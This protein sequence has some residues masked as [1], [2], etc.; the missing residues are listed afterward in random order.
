MACCGGNKNIS[1][2]KDQQKIVDAV[3]QQQQKSSN[4][5]TIIPPVTNTNIKS[6]RSRPGEVVNQCYNCGT[7][8]SLNTC[9]ICLTKLK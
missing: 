6:N 1:I 4:N 7:R 9:P 5:S 2:P 8:T 3:K